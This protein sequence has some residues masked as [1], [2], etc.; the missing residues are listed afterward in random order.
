MLYLHDLALTSNARGL[1]LPSRLLSCAFDHARSRALDTMALIAVQGTER[2]W[3]GYGFE[4]TTPSLE[5]LD[6]LH[7]YGDARFMT[8]STSTR[9]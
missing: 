8:R 2:F 9:E 4:P 6:T 1:G 5:L 3:A 7:T